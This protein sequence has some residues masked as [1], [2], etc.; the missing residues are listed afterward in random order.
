MCDTIFD[1]A[2][3]NPLKGNL[4]MREKGNG[5]RGGG[6]NE[7]K[8]MFDPFFILCPPTDLMDNQ[9]G[10]RPISWLWLVKVFILDM[11]K[12]EKSYYDCNDWQ[13]RIFLPP[14]IYWLLKHN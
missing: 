4:C 14:Q 1:S 13:T 9:F 11:S 5:S 3:E 6:W 8:K 10:L 2:L 7:W 12:I